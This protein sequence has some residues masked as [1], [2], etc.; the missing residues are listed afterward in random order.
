MNEN[1]YYYATAAAMLFVG[2]VVI[3]FV[4]G[5]II[6]LFHAGAGIL[7]GVTLGLVVFSWLTHELAKLMKKRNLL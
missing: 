3:S 6:G 2:F 1:P 7:F 5:G 4:I